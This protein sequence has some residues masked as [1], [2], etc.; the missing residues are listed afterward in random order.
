MLS[1]KSD[2]SLAI[3]ASIAVPGAPMR[4]IIR[5]YLGELEKIKLEISGK[6]LI[7]M[8]VA[9]GPKLGQILEQV[10]EAKLD[11]ALSTREAEL[12]FARQRIA[13]GAGGD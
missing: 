8:G 13:D 11:G 6:D 12:E 10:F 1:G 2:E 3:A 9:E 4:R 7:K 5:V